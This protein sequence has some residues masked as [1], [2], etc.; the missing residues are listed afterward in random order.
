[1]RGGGKRGLW[2]ARVRAIEACL[3]SEETGRTTIAE[4]R[5]PSINTLD[6]R[7]PL[8]PRPLRCASAAYNKGTPR[9]RDLQ[10]GRIDAL[11]LSNEFSD[12]P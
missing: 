4:T 6:D 7:P 10:A 3:V 2:Q 1:V 11:T 12:S 9:S 8:H 5:S